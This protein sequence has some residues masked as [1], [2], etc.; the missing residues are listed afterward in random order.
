MKGPERIVMWF[1]PSLKPEAGLKWVGG[2]AEAKELQ[3]FPLL[4]Q[5]HDVTYSMAPHLP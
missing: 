1:S 4:S 2:E 3:L 5:R